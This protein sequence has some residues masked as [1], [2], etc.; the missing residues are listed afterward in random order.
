TKATR[1]CASR[2]RLAGLSAK[3]RHARCRAVVVL[4]PRANVPPLSQGGFPA[5]GSAW[6]GD[7][8]PCAFPCSSR[9]RA[10]C[11]ERPLRL[12]WGVEGV[13]RGAS[14]WPIIFRT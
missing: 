4:L 5:I 1:E 11:D 7:A 12:L 13:T 9:A 8:V 14:R 2:F 3:A 6:D 10:R